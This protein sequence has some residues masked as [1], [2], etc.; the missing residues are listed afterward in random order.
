MAA[1]LN[2]IVAKKR[3]E[4]ERRLWEEP[5]DVLK[6]RIDELPPP[7]NFS[8]CIWGPDVRLIAEIK[9][10]SPSRGL[11]STN[12]D[13][14]KLAKIYAR[15]GAAAI[16]VLTEVDHF[17][18]SLEYLRKVAQE[19]HPQGIPVLRKDFLFDPYQVYESKAYG[20]DAILLIVAMLKPPLLTQLLETARSLQ[21]QCLVEVHSE[22]ELNEALHAGAEIIGINHRDLRTFKTDTSLTQ[23]LR[24][25]IPLGKVVVSESGITSRKEVDQLKRTGVNAVLIGEALITASD[26]PAKVREL[27]GP[28][29]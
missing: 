9:K 7:M 22:N 6:L 13:P 29:S 19:V 10:A 28:T 12:F 16:S 23:Q 4:L 27:A 24:P 3:T 21:L 17:Q 18:G 5:L 26:I 2:Q 11:L 25:L 20:A 15:Y 14:L 8:G 1:I